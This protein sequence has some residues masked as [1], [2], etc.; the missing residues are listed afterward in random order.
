M[1][2]RRIYELQYADFSNILR[3]ASNLKKKIEKTD[4]EAWTNFVKKHNVPEGAI[5]FR[6]KAETMSGIVSVVIIDGAGAY[7]GYYV[8]SSD[9]AVCLKFESG[10]E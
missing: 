5:L 1:G 3:K 4:K 10:L 7:D 9:D 8:Y 6:G 2:E